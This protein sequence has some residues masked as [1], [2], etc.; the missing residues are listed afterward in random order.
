MRKLRLT[1]PAQASLE[2]I[3]EYTIDNFGVEQAVIY[4]EQLISV[5]E[6]LCTDSFSLGRSC[7]LLLGNDSDIP[8]LLYVLA[9]K[10]YLIYA[11]T[12]DFITIHDF[13]HVRRNLPAIL[14]AVKERRLR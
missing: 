9:G 13:V 3:I 5:A 4:R 6:K 1:A 8:E 11:K 2:E 12:S 7:S 10:H 14:K